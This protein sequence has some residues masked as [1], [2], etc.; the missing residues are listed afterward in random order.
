MSR[1][2]AVLVLA[3]L[4]QLQLVAAERR[5]M[6]L[7]EGTAEQMNLP[8]DLQRT[9]ADNRVDCIFL[10]V[11]PSQLNPA[12]SS[13][14]LVYQQ[15]VLKT[16]SAARSVGAQVHLMFLQDYRYCTGG[17]DWKPQLQDAAAFISRYPTQIQGIHFD[18][19]PHQNDDWNSSKGYYFKLWMN[20]LMDIGA[21]VRSNSALKSKIMSIDVPRWFTDKSYA[22]T[23]SYRFPNSLA[24]YNYQLSVMVYGTSGLGTKL[25]DFTSCEDEI[26]GL[27]SYIGVGRLQYGSRAEMVKMITALRTKY[28]SL[29]NYLGEAIY[30][31]KTLVNDMYKERG[32]TD[33]STG[34]IKRVTQ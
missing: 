15:R 10:S 18:V 8:S 32:I 12:R 3:G 6:Y 21:Y 19:E 30:D 28:S 5:C 24:K 11:Q 7:Y 23:S 29:G 26:K 16:I 1:M 34:K 33:S 14:S 17:R 20:M 4:S 27:P 9:M 13:F 31:A 2:L 22:A 25:S